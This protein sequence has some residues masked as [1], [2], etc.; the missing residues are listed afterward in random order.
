ME[1]DTWEQLYRDAALAST[2]GR[3]ADAR[4]LFQQSI[5]AGGG[6]QV[7]E[8]YFKMEQRSRMFTQA[9]SVIRRAVETFPDA[10]RLFVLYGQSERKGGQYDAAVHVFR[11]GIVRHPR[12]ADLRMGL[13]QT[14]VQKGTARSLREAGRIF[15]D[16]NRVGR[17]HKKDSLY[18]RFRFLQ[19]NPRLNRVFEFFQASAIKTAIVGQ[20][21]LPPSITDVVVDLAQAE[22]NDSFGL[23]GSCLVRCFN[24]HPRPKHLKELTEYLLTRTSQDEVTLETGRRVV[25][26]PT[27]AFVS[28]PNTNVVHD[29]VMR[30]LSDSQTAVIPLDD[31]FLQNHSNPVRAIQEILS[32][33]LGR[34]DLYDSTLP[35]S[36]RRFFGRDRLLVQLGEA[37]QSGQFLGIYGLRKIGKTSIVYQLRDEQLRHDAVAYV[38]LQASLSLS[39][40]NCDA[41]YWEIERA[42]QVR[43]HSTNARLA[44]LLRL[45]KEERF[46]NLSGNSSE[47]RVTFAEDLRTFLDAIA[48]DQ[49]GDIRRVVILL[50]ELERIL[51]VADQP[52]ISGYLEFFGLLRGLAQTERYRGMLSCVVVAANAAISER[53]YWEGRENPVF[54]LYKPFFIPPLPEDECDAM[55]RNLGKGM[56]VYWRREAT[57]AVFSET[58]GH[59][60]LTRILCSYIARHQNQR[61]LHVTQRMVQ[62]HI[63]SFL[64]DQSSMMEQITEL[65]KTHFPEEAHALHQIV[66][67]KRPSGVSDESLRHLLGYH[68][69][70]GENG[71]YRVTLKLLHRWLRKRAG[72]RT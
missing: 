30:I 4:G 41:L 19:G 38:D 9:R 60:F 17:L 61:P 50:D 57:S 18:Q 52:G 69:I 10:V 32:R 39:T 12:D 14:L 28:V 13:A 63:P 49:A 16:L 8:A 23:S 25:L 58:N 65:V 45:G 48:A 35:V 6:P 71:S 56:S 66:L 20:R 68:L 53:G 29:Q 2:E 54:A 22:L 37:V 5:D 59:P 21:D 11:Q 46:S 51:P 72:L 42:L 47:V 62:K 33:Y 43:L 55:I 31:A 64:R 24:S 44:H 1:S 40:R 67:G 34:R 27:L 26:N 3:I 36:G 70:A 7:Y 15:A